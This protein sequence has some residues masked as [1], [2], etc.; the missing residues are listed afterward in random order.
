MELPHDISL[1]KD[2][3]TRLLIRIEDLEAENAQLRSINAELQS[4]LNQNSGNSNKPPSSDGLGKKP[5][6]P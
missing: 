3:V 6:I 4:R 5:A 2:L 1:L